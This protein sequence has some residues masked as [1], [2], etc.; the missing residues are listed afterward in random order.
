MTLRVL[1]AESGTEDTV[2]LNEVL[3]E[4]DGA[5]CWSDWVHVETSHAATWTATAAILATDA[6]DILL[7]DPDLRD[8]QGSETFRRVQAAAPQVP[9][10]LLVEPSAISLAEHMVR[11]GAQDFL[12]KKEVDCEPLARAIRNAMERHRLL[13]AARAT[14]MT[15]PLT[16]LL[17]RPAFLTLAERD[18]LLAERLSRKMLVALAEQAQAAVDGVQRHDLTL[19]GAADDLRRLAGPAALLARLNHSRFGLAVL[20]TLAEPVDEIQARLG[21]AATAGTLAFG[22]VVFD[23]QQPV[24]LDALLEQATVNL[25]KGRACPTPTTTLA[26]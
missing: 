11:D 1:L 9:V 12:L 15:D 22:T 5:R 25:S 26:L 7:L 20:D 8:T 3:T 23:P 2:F 24:S 16:G 21:T 19:I 4:L 17:T 6:V 10:I 14:S 18:R 13:A